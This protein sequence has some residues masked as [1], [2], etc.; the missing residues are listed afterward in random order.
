MCGQSVSP[1]MRKVLIWCHDELTFARC[2]HIT[3][4]PT[5]SSLVRAPD[6][7]PSILG[8]CY[9]LL[10]RTRWIMSTNA[11]HP[12]PACVDNLICLCVCVTV[13]VFWCCAVL[14]LPSACI[15]THHPPAHPPTNPPTNPR[16]T[17]R[18][19]FVQAPRPCR[20]ASAVAGYWP[21]LASH[22]SIPLLLL[23]Y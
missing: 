18:V 9:T 5:S 11:T 4:T 14:S 10:R 20:S 8:A 7:K 6:Q 2:P 13:S 17:C 12:P 23:L 3:P 1:M 19:S 22:G 21:W 16:T 15:R